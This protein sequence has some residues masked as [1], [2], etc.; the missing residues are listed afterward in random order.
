M[1]R[2]TPNTILGFPY[3]DTYSIG[4]VHGDVFGFTLLIKVA[5]L[6]PHLR[7]ISMGSAK[8]T[9]LSFSI[10]GNCI[11]YQTYTRPF[12]VFP[13]V[14]SPTSLRLSLCGSAWAH[15]PIS[16]SAHQPISP[17]AHQPIS[18]SA[19]RRAWRA[20]ASSAPCRPA[21]IALR[22]PERPRP[23]PICAFFRSILAIGAIAGM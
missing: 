21:P 23:R 14:F 17:S 13:Y 2:R 1:F 11:N 18:P 8:E 9:N 7:R 15:Q 5:W 4:F 12:L 16:P 22:R 6:Q 3:L 10:T 19:L 20:S